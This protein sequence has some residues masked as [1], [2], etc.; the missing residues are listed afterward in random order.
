MIGGSLH[1]VK[2]S[3]GY[4][5]LHVLLLAGMVGALFSQRYIWLLKIAEQGYGPYQT[6]SYLTD[7]SAGI[8]IVDLFILR[9]ALKGSREDRKIALLWPAAFLA[10]ALAVLVANNL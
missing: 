4:V 6:A 3:A 10:L 5:T 2:S 9:W 1:Q 8:I 7:V